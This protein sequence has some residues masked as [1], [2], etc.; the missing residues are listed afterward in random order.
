MTPGAEGALR[1]PLQCFLYL[2]EPQLVAQAV[3]G[4]AGLFENEAR[5]DECVSALFS[6]FTVLLLIDRLLKNAYP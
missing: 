3:P 6:T 1:R 2:Q 5:N 4:D